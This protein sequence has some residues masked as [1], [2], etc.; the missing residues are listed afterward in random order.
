MEDCRSTITRFGEKVT[1]EDVEEWFSKAGGV[2]RTV[3]KDASDGLTIK[4]W[5]D[6]IMNK[7]Y[8]AD[9]STLQHMIAGL[10]LDTFALGSDDLL[11]WHVVARNVPSANNGSSPI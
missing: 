11:H 5:V 2:A 1:S 3:L 9:L 7:I 8:L 10:Q 4:A 6:R